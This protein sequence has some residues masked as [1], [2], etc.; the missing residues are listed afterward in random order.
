MSEPYVVLGK[1]PGVVVVREIPGP[2]WEVRWIP[3]PGG[4]PVTVS[5]H[6]SE[7]D[8]HAAAWREVAFRQR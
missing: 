7:A 4:R 6:A 1:R 5:E 8:A 3:A 2:G